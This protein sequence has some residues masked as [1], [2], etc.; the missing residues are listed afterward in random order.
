MSS[1][2]CWELCEGRVFSLF[3]LFFYLLSLSCSLSSCLLLACFVFS[4]D[5]LELDRRQAGS[6]G[7]KPN[8]DNLKFVLFFSLMNARS[9][10]LELCSFLFCCFDLFYLCLD[11]VFATRYRLLFQ[12]RGNAKPCP[13]CKVPTEKNGGWCVNTFTNFVHPS[14]FFA[15]IFDLFNLQLFLCLYLF[16]SDCLKRMKSKHNFHTYLICVETRKH[17][18]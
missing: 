15:H 5:L 16:S 3:C 17:T 12:V 9:R 11:C 4:L 2:Q 18:A 14:F 10:E 7:W 13:R 8:L 1:L 6:R